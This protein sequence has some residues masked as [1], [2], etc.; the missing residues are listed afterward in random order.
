MTPQEHNKM[1]GIFHL[2]YGAFSG[3]LMLAIVAFMFFLAAA[4]PQDGPVFAP[5][6]FMG[7]FFFFYALVFTLPSFVAGYAML[8]R[9]AW[10]RTA[11]IVAAVVETMSM[12][13]GTAVAVYSFWFMFSDVG[14]RFYEQV[15]GEADGSYR[16]APALSEAPPRPWWQDAHARE[17]V[18]EPV[19]PQQDWRGE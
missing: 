19:K 12:P 6:M 4:A 13:I 16:A 2:I 7:V 9:K 8:K 17:R 14:K 10:A 5:F 18:R 3:L 1:L 11:S 15:A